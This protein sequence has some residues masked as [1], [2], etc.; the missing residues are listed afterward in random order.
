MLIWIYKVDGW[1]IIILKIPRYTKIILRMVNQQLEYYKI[2][3]LIG[4]SFISIIVYLSL[5]PNPSKAPDYPLQD[6]VWHLLA[7]CT[8]MGWF[9]QLYTSQK[10]Q[11]IIAVAFILMGILLE[12]IQGWGG[13]RVF[14]YLDMLANTAGVF[15]GWWISA[16]Y[17]AGWL[18]RLDRAI[19]H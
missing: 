11:I 3:I 19:S 16:R 2:W 4:C 9:S 15:L 18:A 5:I 17:C 7:Y 13:Y 1:L 12:I 10:A 6:K 14:E 8:L